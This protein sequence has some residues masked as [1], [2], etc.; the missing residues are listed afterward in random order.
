MPKINETLLDLVQY[1]EFIPEIRW[2]FEPLNP[3]P[4]N[5]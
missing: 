5:P 4:L 3:E 2:V 1:F